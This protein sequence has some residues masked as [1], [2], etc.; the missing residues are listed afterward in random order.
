MTPDEYRK[1]I[2]EG[3]KEAV[4]DEFRDIKL[5]LG[6]WTLKAIGAALITAIIVGLIWFLLTVN[7]WHRIPSFPQSH[8]QNQ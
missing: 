5:R 1:L 3:F 6:G 2:K 7:G 4:R 8:T